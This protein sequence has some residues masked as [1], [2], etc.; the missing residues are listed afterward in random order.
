MGRCRHTS[1]TEISKIILA[2]IGNETY[3]EFADKIG[4][5]PSTLSYICR[6]KVLPTPQIIYKIARNENEYNAM[7]KSCDYVW[8]EKNEK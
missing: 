2:I 5:N 3:S 8:K 4:I 6:G 1:P 7:M